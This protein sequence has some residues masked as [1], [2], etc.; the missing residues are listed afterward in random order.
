MKG[1]TAAGIRALGIFLQWWVAETQSSIHDLAATIAPA[2]SRSILVFVE[3]QRLRVYDDMVQLGAPLIDIVCDRLGAKLPES[4]TSELLTLSERGG[5]A[6]LV[7]CANKAFIR[8]LRLPAA[9]LP[10]LKSAILLQLPKLLPIDSS[11]LLIA[12]TLVSS[13]AKSG[14]VDLAAVKRSDI[15]PVFRMLTTSGFRMTK[16]QLGEAPDATPRFR[17]HRT[18]TV[19]QESTFKR[20]DRMLIAAAALLGLACTAVA[21]TESYR[22]ERALATA[23]AQIRV[24]S[25]AALERRQ[26][27][28]SKLEPLIA[29]SQI[30]KNPTLASLLSELT[31]R[32]P[33]DTWVTML[34][35]KD[36][37][38]RIVGI[39]SDSATLVKQLSSSALL[40][41]VE[42][43]SSMSAGMGT[44]K[45]RF[46]IAAEFVG[47]AP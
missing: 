27:L 22:A 37:R 34:E 1:R 16:T 24:A 6:R 18:D 5:R 42:L 36:R 38:L 11:Q 40:N 23:K 15:D 30:E 45:D 14:V 21:A 31:D 25:S 7:L 26:L 47:N 33:Q 39:S 32:I 35:L 17:F 13:D 28:L 19:G 44:G 3:D 41:D 43:L 20:G 4:V 9:A 12:F 46:E 10:H 2:W 29:V 8:Q